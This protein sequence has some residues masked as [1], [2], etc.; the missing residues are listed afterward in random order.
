MSER[1]WIDTDPS[2]RPGGFEVDDGYALLQAF[3]APQLQLV[4]ISASY[5]NAPLATTLEIARFMVD[6]FLPVPCPVVAGAAGPAQLGEPS[7]ASRALALALEEAPL[8]F[9]ALGPL[10]TLATTLLQEPHLIPQ[11]RQVVA[12]AGRRPGQRLTESDHSRP[13]RDFNFE[14]DPRAFEVLLENPVALVLT[15][16]E[17]SRQLWI[18]PSDLQRLAEGPP[19]CRWLVGASLDWLRVWKAR[20]GVEGFHPFDTL[21]VGYLMWPELYAWQDVHVRIGQGADDT[22]DSPNPPEKPYLWTEATG[23]GRPARYCHQVGPDFKARLLELLMSSP[24]LRRS[25]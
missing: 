25:K 21:A 12:V 13:H 18:G 2:V 11:L 3:R 24:M 22:W 1:I 8:T 20:F 19:D 14:Q 16:W 4:G 17:A 7:A 10:T 9:V 5:G 6:Q 23:L 15:P